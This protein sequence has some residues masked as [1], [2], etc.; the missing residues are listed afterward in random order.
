MLHVSY[1]DIHDGVSDDMLVPVLQRRTGSTAEGMEHIIE[2]FHKNQEFP[3]SRRIS[4]QFPVI[5]TPS[6]QVSEQVCH[7]SD[8]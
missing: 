8:E 1:N 7:G 3:S 4:Q 2:D 5:L 6:E